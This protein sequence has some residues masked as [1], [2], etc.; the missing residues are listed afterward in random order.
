VLLESERRLVVGY[1]QR[2]RPDGLVVLTAGNLS[3]RNGELVAITPT[4]LDYDLLRPELVSVVS[5]DGQVVEGTLPQSSETP[6]HMAAYRTLSVRAAVH[7]HSPYATA[8]ATLLNEVPPIHYLFADLGG[9]VRVAPYATFGT[10]E[11]ADSVSKALAGRNAALLA[12]HGTITVGDSLDRAYGRALLLEWLCALYYRS[13]LLGE[14][15]RLDA[16]EVDRV[17]ARLRSLSESA[18]ETDITI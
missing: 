6:L 2:L 16:G 4:G 10:R 14:P 15:A 8:L 9:A 11:L 1:A 18:G 5:L 17:A 3:V 13:R 12:N 7:T